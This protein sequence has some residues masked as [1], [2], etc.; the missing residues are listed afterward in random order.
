MVA[1]SLQEGKTL[2]DQNTNL[3]NNS[4]LPE[5]FIQSNLFV[6]FTNVYISVEPLLPPVFGTTTTADARLNL[7]SR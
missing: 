6:V 2:V 3:K 1:Q 5:K 4:K 7:N